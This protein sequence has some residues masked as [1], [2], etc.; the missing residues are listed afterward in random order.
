MQL[1]RILLNAAVLG[2]VLAASPLAAVANDAAA[3]FAAIN[4]SDIKAHI[5]V[6]ADDSFEGREAGTSGGHAAGGYLVERIQR[7]GLKPAG[8]G[9]SYFQSFRGNCRNILAMLE[10]SDPVLKDQYVLVGAHYDHV[11]YG[12]RRNSFGPTGQIHNGADDNASGVAGVLEVIEG[13]QA[14]GTPPRRSILFALWDGEEQGLWGSKHWV[15]APTVPAEQLVFVLNADMIGHLRDQRVMVYGTRTSPG[16]RKMVSLCNP[17]TDLLL[18]FTWDLKANSDHHSFLAGNVPVLMLHTGLND[19]YHRPSDDAH[20]INH[21]GSQEVARL[22]FSIALELASEPDTRRFRA[23]ARQETPRDLAELEK[24]MPPRPPRLGVTLRQGDSGGVYLQQVFADLPADRSGL[25][26]GD[27]VVRFAGRE[28]TRSDDLVQR[29]VA[30]DSP[31]ALLIER[32][33]SEASQS[34]ELAVELDGTPLRLGISWRVDEG[35][36]GS[37]LLS[38]VVAASPAYL[39]GLEVADRIYRV[40]GQDFADDRQFLSLVTEGYGPYQLLVERQGRLKNLTIQLPRPE[41]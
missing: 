15:A 34:L 12:N 4:A 3:A 25:R 39:A 41:I 22:L 7:Y 17:L 19:V 2:T 28:V 33:G 16:L 37:V 31:A 11:G 21:Q 8:D 27:R 29:I 1:A 35:E 40:N 36:P 24:P 14:L 13:F 20:L 9:R 6:L 18:D 26:A 32:P 30:A 23:A 38:E 5:D 10:G